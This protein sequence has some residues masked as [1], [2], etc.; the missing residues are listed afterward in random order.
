[1]PSSCAN[2]DERLARLF[3]RFALS[4]PAMFFSAFRLPWPAAY[5]DGRRHRLFRQQPAGNRLFGLKLVMHGGVDLR[6]R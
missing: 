6:Q 2:K 1:M 3:L 5:P 4:A